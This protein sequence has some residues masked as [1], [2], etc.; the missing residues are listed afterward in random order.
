M[1]KVQDFVRLIVLSIVFQVV[2]SAAT[3]AQTW[4]APK[5]N[6]SEGGGYIFWEYD[7]TKNPQPDGAVANV[8]YGYLKLMDSDFNYI[9]N[10]GNTESDNSNNPNIYVFQGF[11]YTPDLNQTYFLWIFIDYTDNNGVL[12]RGDDGTGRST[13]FTAVP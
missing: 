6:V 2:L 10:Y 4:I 11:L 13:E 12:H 8:D 5:G 3:S 7:D 9:V 1:K